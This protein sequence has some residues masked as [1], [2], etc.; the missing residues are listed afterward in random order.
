MRAFLL[1]IIHRD[2]GLN[3]IFVFYYD[4]KAPRAFST[5]VR[6]LIKIISTSQMA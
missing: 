2:A 6:I 3:D 5:N 4:V 1:F